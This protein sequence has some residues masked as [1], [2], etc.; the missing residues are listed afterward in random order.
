MKTGQV[1]RTNDRDYETE[2]RHVPLMASAIPR[3]QTLC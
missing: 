2:L 1:E 3:P